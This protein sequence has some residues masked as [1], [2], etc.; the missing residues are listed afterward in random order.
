MSDDIFKA[1]A[2]KYFYH[3]CDLLYEYGEV[4]NYA[5]PHHGEALLNPAVLDVPE[6]KYWLEV[7]T[8]VAG[9]IYDMDADMVFFLQEGKGIAPEAHDGVSRVA[10]Q[11]GS[12]D[13]LIL[14]ALS[15]TGRAISIMAP[16]KRDPRAQTVHD[17]STADFVDAPIDQQPHLVNNY[18]PLLDRWGLLTEDMLDGPVDMGDVPPGPLH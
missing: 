13:V 1:L 5:F 15:K 3:G 2:E 6:D 9:Q 7:M 18:Y 12:F 16:F 4:L 14:G 10:D 8:N 17:I 11:Q